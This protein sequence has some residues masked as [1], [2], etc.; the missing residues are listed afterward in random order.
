[1]RWRDV[2]RW[3]GTTAEERM[4]RYPC[5]DA[6]PDWNEAWYRGVDVDAPPANVLRWLC[7]LRAA[8]YSYDW[9]DNRGRRSPRALTPGLENLEPG[10][11]VMTIFD[12]A[13]FERGRH[14]TLMLRR[15]GLFPPLAVSY[16]IAEAGPARS[17]LLA[18][19]AVRL[20]PG[21]RDRLIRSLMPWADWVMMR[22]QLL[23]LKKYAEVSARESD[24]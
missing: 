14:L 1:M 24:A 16:C 21:L 8:P 3:W 15:P 23:T 19:L 18:K 5:D 7:Q 17:R 12:V 4:L 20:R 6:L 10:Q 13:S 2:G 22:K 9:I 11:R